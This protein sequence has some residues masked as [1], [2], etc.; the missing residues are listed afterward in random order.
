MKGA[1][2]Q[3]KRAQAR[4]SSAELRGQHGNGEAGSASK[5]CEQNEVLTALGKKVQEAPAAATAAGSMSHGEGGG[6][7]AGG[8]WVEWWGRAVAECLSV[9]TAEG[10]CELQG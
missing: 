8:V 5:R 9:G 1:Y 6:M 4:S 3:A 2:T 10:I 7:G